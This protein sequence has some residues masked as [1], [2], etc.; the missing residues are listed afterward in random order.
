MRRLTFILLALAAA[1]PAF[2]QDDQRPPPNPQMQAERA[3]F[4]EVCSPDIEHFCA[5]AGQD[6]H[7]RHECMMANQAKFSKP[8]Q[9]ALS[10]MEARRAAHQGDHP[11]HDHQ[12]PQ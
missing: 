7:A 12:D 6:R 9:D 11:Q 4:R 2:A 10:E 1:T 8:C 5:D 3:H